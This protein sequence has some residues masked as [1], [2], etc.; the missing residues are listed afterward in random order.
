MN[1]LKDINKFEK[2]KLIKEVISEKEGYIQE[3]NAE[4]IGRL[5]CELGAGRKTKNDKIDLQVGVVLNK[6]TGDFVAKGDKL[7][8]DIC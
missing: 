3:I 4:E 2:A 1:I 8:H 5:S 7:V 6:K